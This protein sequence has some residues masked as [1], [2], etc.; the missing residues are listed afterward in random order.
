MLTFWLMQRRRQRWQALALT[1]GLVAPIEAVYRRFLAREIEVEGRDFCD[2]AGG[3]DQPVETFAIVNV[4]LPRRYCT[5]L[6][7]NLYERRMASIA[8]QLCGEGMALD[9]DQLV[10]KPP[11]QRR[12]FEKA[13]GT[14]SFTVNANHDIEILAISGLK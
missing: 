7:D 11:E 3:Y 9:Y 6:V 13:A 10:A 1:V 8:Q 12:S 5:E 14:V 2:M 4:M